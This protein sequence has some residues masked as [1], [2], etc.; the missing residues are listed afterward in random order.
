MT[1]GDTVVTTERMIRYSMRIDRSHLVAFGTAVWIAG[2][3]APHAQIVQTPQSAPQTTVQTKESQ[4]RIR[5]AEALQMLKDGNARFLARRMQLRNLPKQAEAAAAGEYPVATV[6]GCIDSRAAPELIFDTGIG[7]IF[8]PRIAGNVLTDD[9]LGNLEFASRVAGSKLIVV[10]GHND[11]GAIKGACDRVELG[12]LTG[13]LTYLDPAVR[14][15]AADGSTPSGSDPVFVDKVAHINVRMAV[16]RIREQSA[17]L[18][19]L[20]EQGRLMVVGAMLDVGT[21]KVTFLDGD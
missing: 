18:R 5:A 4:T 11:C 15:A 17:V 10:L 7:D 1:T 8:S 3:G 14:E 6:L 20:I 9:M 13:A 16:R 12:H 19:E 21:G 2:A